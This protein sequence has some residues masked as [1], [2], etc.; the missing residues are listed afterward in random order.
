MGVEQNNLIE[1]TLFNETLTIKEASKKII[2]LS[3]QN[4]EFWV[5]EFILIDGVIY[6]NGK[7]NRNFVKILIDDEQNK[8]D[9]SVLYEYDYQTPLNYN[10]NKRNCIECI[11]KPNW[12]NKVRTKELT[13]EVLKIEK[14]LNSL[15]YSRSSN[16]GEYYVDLGYERILKVIN[17]DCIFYHHE[18]T[19]YND[20]LESIKWKI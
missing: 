3:E 17:S 15:D 14:Y 18:Y 10:L 1:M 11:F 13:E 19:K 6:G 9:Y 20:I 5:K 8:Y 12:Y 16:E 7:N 2:K 4:R